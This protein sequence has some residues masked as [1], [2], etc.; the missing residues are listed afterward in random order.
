MSSTVSP[1]GATHRRQGVISRLLLCLS[2]LI[3]AFLLYLLIGQHPV[4]IQDQKKTASIQFEADQRWVLLPDACVMVNWKVDGIRAVYLNG[5]GTVGEGQETVCLDDGQ[6]ELTIKF[7]WLTQP[8]ETY[9]LPVEALSTRPETWGLLLLALPS[10]IVAG[11][12]YPTPVLSRVSR[13]F[14]TGWRNRRL[15]RILTYLAVFVLGIAALLIVLEIGL[16]F[17]FT[18]FGTERD[19]MLYVY[20]ADQIRELNARFVPLPYLGYGLAPGFGDHNSQ[21]YRGAEISI[22]KPDEVYR[23][24]ALGSSVTYGTRLQTDETYPAQL[25]AILRDEYGYEHVEVIN[26]GV[27]GYSS[28]EYLVALSFQLLDLS[29][30]LVIVYENTNDTTARYVDPDFYT[31]LN[32]MRGIWQRELVEL[33]SSTLYRFIAINLGWM[34]DP[35]VNTAFTL[36][37]TVDIAACVNAD[38]RPAD[39]ADTCSE[40][41][42][43]PASDLLEI[44]PPSYY[45]RNLRSLVGVARANDVQLLFPS[46]AYFPD[47]L[48]GNENQYMTYPDRQAAVAEANAILERL[49]AELDVP[50]YDLQAN[51][52]YNPDFWYDGRHMTA[53]GAREVA[54]QLAAFLVERQ[55]IPTE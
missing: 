34:D 20:S 8:D 41:D 30:N 14:L 32:L 27:A 54:E 43:M 9:R 36:M 42:D 4:T 26:A 31:G 40:L 48:P 15:R 35:D 53:L 52:P 25:Q 29:P 51:M 24:V 39:E 1:L 13:L 37:P 49:S 19:R 11:V 5:R 10:L 12:L 16:R 21:G 23:I 18:R 55:L 45:E 28:W 50:F 2:I 6:P 46:W 7:P 3:V 47:S 22:P 38:N 17:Y 33:P 44:N